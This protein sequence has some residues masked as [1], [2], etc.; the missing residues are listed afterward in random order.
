MKL[1]QNDIAA[2]T[3]LSRN[4]ISV[5]ERGSRNI[6]LNNIVTIFQVPNIEMVIKDNDNNTEN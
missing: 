4:Y 3:N 1:N 6:S 5:V 2:L